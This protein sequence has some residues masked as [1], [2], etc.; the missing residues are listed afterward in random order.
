M[1]IKPK[2]LEAYPVAQNKKPEWL[3]AYP[4]SEISVESGD[5]Q[6]DS[7]DSFLDA[8]EALDVDVAEQE[9]L[10]GFY[11]GKPS[12]ISWDFK[13]FKPS[14]FASKGN[15]QVKVAAH[16]VASL[17]SVR[18]QFGK[19]IK[20]TS[21]YRDKGHNHKVGG[22][23]N[24][25]HMHGDAVDINIASYS[26]EERTLLMQLLR[27]EGFTAFGSYTNSPNMLHADKRGYNAKWHHGRGGHPEW[28]KR[29]LVGEPV[30]PNQQE[31]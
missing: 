6:W 14:E 10:V 27:Q 25:R 23:K 5:K 30:I 29:G 13:H 1:V 16:M 3:S 4:T 31:T 19:P 8:Q 20:V 12:E 7:L 2:W 21:G 17:D 11:E 9:D 28:F 26:E 24:S 18:E 22:A 15:G